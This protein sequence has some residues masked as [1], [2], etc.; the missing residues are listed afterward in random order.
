MDKKE[1][2]K[3]H[4]KFDH[5]PSGK[6]DRFLYLLKENGIDGKDFKR[7]KETIRSLLSSTWSTLSFTIYFTPQATPRPRSGRFGFY[8]KGAK[9]NFKLF[10]DYI[11]KIREEK[12][13]PVITT[14]T[15]FIVKS[16]FPI[17]DNMSK[18]EKI[19]AE[20]GLIRPISKPDWDNIGKTYSDMIQSN[21]LLEDSTVIEGISKKYYSSKPRVEIGIM[22]MNEYDSKYNKRKVEGWKSYK[23]STNVSDKDSLM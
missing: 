16:Y 1:I 9:D 19:M 21:L 13:V 11:T 4:E 12:Q 8:V 18:L 3:Y 6:I 22:Y 14:S 5:I 2:K 7:I 20:L 10:E 17:P 15:K 23:E